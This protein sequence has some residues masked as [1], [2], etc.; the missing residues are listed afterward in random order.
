MDDK[1]IKKLLIKYKPHRRGKSGIAKEKK[2][3]STGHPNVFLV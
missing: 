2:D 3:R 1:R